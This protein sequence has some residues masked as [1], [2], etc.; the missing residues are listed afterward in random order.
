[1]RKIYES[2]NL[3]RMVDKMSCS[4]LMKFYICIVRIPLFVIIQPLKIQKGLLKG[5][6]K[7]YLGVAHDNNYPDVI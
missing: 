5:S 6:Y 1:M 2:C 3:E 7:L 4:E